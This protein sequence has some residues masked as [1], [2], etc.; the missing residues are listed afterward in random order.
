MVP[1]GQV[2]PRA[3]EA[4]TLAE[5]SAPAEV[6]MRHRLPQFTHLFADENYAAG[7]YSYLW[8]DAM[9][10][11]MW[12]AFVEA[13]DPWDATAAAGLKAVMA[14]GDSVDQAELFRQ[15]RGRD[16]SVNALLAERGFPLT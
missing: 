4:E 1:D 3:F 16:P 13:G 5:I 11:D 10:A 9:A 14:A 6:P 12:Q 2:D 7:Y 8:S 15:F